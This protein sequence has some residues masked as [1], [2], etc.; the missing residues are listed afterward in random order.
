[1]GYNHVVKPQRKCCQ[2][3]KLAACMMLTVCCII[4]FNVLTTPSYAIVEDDSI[5]NGAVSDLPDED[6]AQLN[7]LVQFQNSIQGVELLRVG[8]GKAI[9]S[10]WGHAAIRFVM[11]TRYPTK[12]IVIG[13]A[14]DSGFSI[15]YIKGI[16]GAYKFTLQAYKLAQFI[17]QYASEEK[18]IIYSLIVPT[19]QEDR[20]RLVRKIISFATNESERGKYYF[21]DKNCISMVIQV[22]HDSGLMPEINLKY[23]T[24]VIPENG[25][26]LLQRN[27]ATP[28]YERVL[29]DTKRWLEADLQFSK[30][31][32]KQGKLSSADL[33]KIFGASDARLN[34]AI[35]FSNLSNP[36][37]KITVLTELAKRE[38]KPSIQPFIYRSQQPEFYSLDWLESISS[39]GSGRQSFYS[40]KKDDLKTH[41]ANFARNLDQIDAAYRVV[42]Q[43]HRAKVNFDVIKQ[44]CP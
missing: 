21:F 27:L 28:F 19:S 8:P 10:R 26:A 3:V 33:E 30:N 32:S 25:A 41:C 11:D 43:N 9:E 1:M 36:Y 17:N 7:R 40:L 31:I 22:F 42:K 35:W 4:F 44:L 6:L 23:K 18:R 34:L 38:I 14:A 13:F 12:D 29:V 15:D 20:L 37:Y 39:N 24:T 2:D 5:I 16:T